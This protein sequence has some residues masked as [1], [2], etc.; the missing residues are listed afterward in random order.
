MWPRNSCVFRLSPRRLT[1]PPPATFPKMSANTSPNWP[2]TSP[3]W[4]NTSPKIRAVFS[5][6]R[7]SATA[8]SVAASARHAPAHDGR[9]IQIGVQVGHAV[10]DAVAELHEDGPLDRFATLQALRVGRA[11]GVQIARAASA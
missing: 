6:R 8:G 9:S 5:L 2:N 1:G 4:P 11:E 7:L 3:N 10:P